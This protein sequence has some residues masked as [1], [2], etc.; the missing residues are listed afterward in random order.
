MTSDKFFNLHSKH[1]ATSESW[2]IK[3]DN[4]LQKKSIQVLFKL[5]SK[6]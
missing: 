5:Q 3:V 1:A 4:L 6:S 2:Y